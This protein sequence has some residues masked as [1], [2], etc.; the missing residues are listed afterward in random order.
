MRLASAAVLMAGLGAPVAAQQSP[1]PPGATKLDQGVADRGLQTGRVDLRTDLRQQNDFGSVYRFT[2]QNPYGGP[3]RG[4]SML[5]RIEGDTAAVFPESV[6]VPTA[7]GDR[8]V[9]PPGT[10]FY[11]GGL[12]RA[13]PG[14]AEQAVQRAP[15]YLDLRADALVRGTTDRSGATIPPP[16]ATPAPIDSL[17]TSEPYRVRAVT[18]LIDRA[19]AAQR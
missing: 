6:Y 12:P 18:S 13:W 17:W 15:N 1:L 2:T 5:M 16:S 10:T 4:R 11:I 7:Q 8:A 9:V 19:S 3:G 14:P